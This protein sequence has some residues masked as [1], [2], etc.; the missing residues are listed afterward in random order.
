MNRRSKLQV[1]K[2]AQTYV[3]MALTDLYKAQEYVKPIP[4]LIELHNRIGLIMQDVIG[5]GGDMQQLQDDYQR[6]PGGQNNE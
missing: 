4:T 6:P 1:L 2:R 3:G 5:I